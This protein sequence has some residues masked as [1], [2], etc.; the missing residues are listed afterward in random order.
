MGFCESMAEQ[1]FD[2]TPIAK[3]YKKKRENKGVS[4]VKILSYL[5]FF[6]V[7]TTSIEHKL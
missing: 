6:A 5:L 4:E 1:G 2:S 3:R 7:T